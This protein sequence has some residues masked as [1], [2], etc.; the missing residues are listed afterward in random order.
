MW[1][2]PRRQAGLTL[3]E[4]ATGLTII[5]LALTLGVSGVDEW[6]HNTRLRSGAEGIL[7]GLQL[8]RAE[9][10]KQNMTVR[11]QLVD[12]KGGNN[13]TVSTAG[14]SWFVSLTDVTGKCDQAPATPPPLPT[15]PDANN[16]YI[17]QARPASEGTGNNTIHAG[18]A[19]IAYNGFGGRNPVDGSLANIAIDITPPSTD[20]CL[21]NGGTLRCLRVTVSTMGQARICDPALAST[22]PKGC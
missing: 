14:T 19:V 15:E 13:C 21:A 3:I 12:L 20:R 1:L 4:L 5:G 2:R 22:D 11:F 17:I 7:N 8:A 18:A 6:V 10:V 9:A 16:P